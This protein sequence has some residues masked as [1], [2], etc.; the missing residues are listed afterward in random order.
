MARERMAIL[1]RCLCSRVLEMMLESPQKVFTLFF[2]GLSS[3]L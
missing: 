3:D 1:R 2:A